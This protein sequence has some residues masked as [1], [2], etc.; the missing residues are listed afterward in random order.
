MVFVT[1]D[2]ARDTPERLR[3]WLDQ[4]PGGE[5]FVGLRGTAG[6]VAAAESAAEVAVAHGSPTTGDA[7]GDYEVGHAAQIM[8]YTP[9]DRAHLAYPSGVRSEDWIADLPRMMDRWGGDRGDADTAGVDERGAARRA[10]AAAV[11]AG[12]TTVRAGFAVPRRHDG[13]LH[14]ARQRRRRR[15][16]GR[17]PVAGG[18]RDH[19]DE[20]RGRRPSWTRSTRSTCPGGTT[21]VVPGGA[22][23]MSDA[24]RGG[25]GRGHR[26]DSSSQF[27]RRDRDRDVQVLDWD[28][29][30]DR[31]ESA[32]D[33][34][35]QGGAVT[36]W[37][38]ASKE[39][40]S[41][42]FRAYPGIWLF[43]ALL[44]AGYLLAFRSRPGGS[45]AR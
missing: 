33:V 17:G 41:W 40:W 18:G 43:M 8:A 42:A 26:A 5:G 4:F 23:I 15:H 37:C 10:R 28:A 22:H 6:E 21:R 24:R 30:V 44:L 20:R 14:H 19:A 1:T 27:E 3:H 29:M 36:W 16:P 45:G 25:R 38:A 7:G 2:P 39:P 31:I 35:G 34:A 9:D 32:D 12:A 13:G 11:T